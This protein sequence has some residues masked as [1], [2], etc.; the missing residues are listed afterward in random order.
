MYFPQQLDSVYA[1]VKAMSDCC[2]D[3]T[4]RLKVYFSVENDIKSGVFGIF[5]FF[6]L[7]VNGFILIDEQNLFSLQSLTQ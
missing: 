6:P 1:D 2:Q 4:N 7:G 3:M 5:V